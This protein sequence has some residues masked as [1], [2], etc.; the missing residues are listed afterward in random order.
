MITKTVEIFL[1]KYQSVGYDLC[2]PDEKYN[3]KRKHTNRPR[4]R[5]ERRELAE[6]E[7]AKI[8]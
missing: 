6:N 8:V 7:R 5:R 3:E 1:G 4:H 2:K